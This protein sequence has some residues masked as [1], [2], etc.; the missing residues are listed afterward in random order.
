MF[1]FLAEVG[2][3]FSTDCIKRVEAAMDWKARLAS[4]TLSNQL[5]G[6]SHRYQQLELSLC[7][8][9]KKRL[10]LSCKAI[11]FYRTCVHE[12]V[13]QNNQLC[14]RLMLILVHRALDSEGKTR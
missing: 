9:G 4:G 12:P 10:Q 3:T 14:G 1:I 7:R 8:A 2:Q 6:S 11:F 13:A 5:A